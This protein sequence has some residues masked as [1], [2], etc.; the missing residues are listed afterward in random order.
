[1]IQYSFSCGFIHE[2]LSSQNKDTNNLGGLQTENII[3][4]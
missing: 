3:F 1:M 4:Q 2:L